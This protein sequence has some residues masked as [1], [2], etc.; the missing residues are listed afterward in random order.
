MNNA[1]AIIKT[2]INE[3]DGME[4]RVWATEDGT[5]NVTLFDLDAEQT[6]HIARHGIATLEAAEAF[7]KKAANV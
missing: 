3:G 6:V 7:A 1:T 5:F 2:F 4:A